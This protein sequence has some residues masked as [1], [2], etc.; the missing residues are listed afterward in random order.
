MRNNVGVVDDFRL[1]AFE[2][3]RDVE[4]GKFF[5]DLISIKLVDIVLG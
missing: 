4:L 5:D 2:V 3:S 1:A